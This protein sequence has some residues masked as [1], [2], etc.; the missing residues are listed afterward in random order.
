[1]HGLPVRFMVRFTALPAA[2]AW[3][4]ALLAQAHGAGG[5]PL[6]CAAGATPTDALAALL[7]RP[8]RPLTDRAPETAT[9]PAS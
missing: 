3:E 4:A 5:E 7:T 8:T 1:M 2:G 9:V 6:A